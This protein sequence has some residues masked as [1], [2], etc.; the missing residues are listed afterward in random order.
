MQNMVE[1]F[2]HNTLLRPKIFNLQM[3]NI[4]DQPQKNAL[5]ES[6][7]LN[8]KL[9]LWQ[10]FLQRTL[11]T[12][13]T[14]LLAAGVI[15][16]FAYNWQ[17]LSRF[18]KFALVQMVILLF[19]GLSFCMWNRW[20]KEV[21]LLGLALSLGSAFAL[22]GQIYQTGA[23]AWELFIVW[24]FS[25][26]PIVLL[27]PRPALFLLLWITTSLWGILFTAIE[28]DAPLDA[29]DN[30]VL[31]LLMW[32]ACEGGISVLEKT[33]LLRQ[34]LRWLPRIV[35]AVA[36]CLASAAVFWQISMQ[37]GGSG[38]D[39]ITVALLPDAAKT[40]LIPGYM[41]LL[42]VMTYF[43]TRKQPDMF[44]ISLGVFGAIGA[45]TVTLLA[46]ISLAD[47]SGL[48]LSG[49][50]IIGAS[51][52]AVV[53]I[54]KLR[55]QLYA[56]LD[57]Q[58]AETHSL[59]LGHSHEQSLQKKLSAKLQDYLISTLNLDS[60]EAFFKQQ[61][62]AEE[63]ALPW[64]AN[65]LMS[66]GIWIGVLLVAFFLILKT[67]VILW[68]ALAY[69]LGLVLCNAKN[70]I[71][72]KVAFSLVIIGLLSILYYLGETLRF[73]PGDLSFSL[74]ALGLFALTWLFIYGM[75]AKTLSAA[76]ALG[77]LVNILSNSI[78]FYSTLPTE[79]PLWQPSATLYA[80]AA[81]VAACGVSGI[82]ILPGLWAGGPF[83]RYGVVQINLQVQSLAW[84]MVLLCAGLAFFGLFD[85][86]SMW[87][88][89]CGLS[90][91][92]LILAAILWYHK[93]LPATLALI[94]GLGLALLAFFQPAIAMGIVLYLLGFSM[95]NVLVT[96]IAS[97]YLGASLVW[98]YYS[99]QISLLDKSF[100]LMGSGVLILLMAWGSCR[101]LSKLVAKQ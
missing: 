97:T 52:L 73:R 96:G 15:F 98:Y 70:P 42:A 64:Y 92:L 16:F 45:L 17:S 81:L 82:L 39:Y 7:G 79:L 58:Q 69:L 99:L 29:L 20:A 84:G 46:N 63:Q 60:A 21:A 1:F 90:A 93:Q 68:G 47:F 91:A 13:G 37:I 53:I 24:S 38:D 41:A 2:L 67:T 85:P 6:F 5:L 22:F 89:R 101:F 80:A 78:W 100:I 74:C 35:G 50:L 4:L 26:L 44:F 54:L 65:L 88:S 23:D 32:G 55:K 3:A 75:P 30:I 72:R 48:L 43:Y 28:Y 36:F 9:P 40:L 49:L 86:L 51:I 8:A 11:A 66:L 59:S 19:T 18:H 27:S 14:L 34:P 87:L 71:G 61:K 56:R 25:L 12:L 62:V 95:G 77:W 83:R 10:L 76:C 94:S 57:K 31:L 33:Q